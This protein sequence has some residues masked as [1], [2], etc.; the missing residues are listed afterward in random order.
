M[1][2]RSEK[3]VGWILGPFSFGSLQVFQC[4]PTV[5]KHAFEEN[6]GS[7]RSFVFLSGAALNPDC[8]LAKCGK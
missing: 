4:L 5:E 8:L 2:P 3:V 7:K 1:S 6:W